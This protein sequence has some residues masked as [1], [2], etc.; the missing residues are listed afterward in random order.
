MRLRDLPFFIDDVGDAPCVFVLRRLGR[1][2]RE[3]DLALGVAEQ[4]ERETELLREGGVLL[5]AVEA[6]AED[7]GVFGF[8]LLREVP[9]PGTFL[10]STGCVGLR[11]EP[12]DD[13]L[14]AQVAEAHA[15]AVVIGDVEVGSGV[16]WLEHGRFPPCQ[17]LYDAAKAHTFI[18]S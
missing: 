15:V 9:E 2:V 12:E 13:F 3:A 16:A 17:H 5:F 14:S 6:D 1:S 7:P 18:V 10:R 8:V 11:V 4:R